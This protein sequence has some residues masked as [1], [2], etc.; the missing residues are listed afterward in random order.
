M[1]PDFSFYI[2]LPYMYRYGPG[3]C[4]GGSGAF[5]DSLVQCFQAHGGTLRLNAEV[6]EV[7]IEDGEARGLVLDDGEQIRAS[8]AVV[9]GL[10]VTQVFPHMVP[11]VELP[12][13][14]QHRI[15]NLKHSDF[16]AMTVHLALKEPLK[17]KAMGG[18]H[19]GLL[20]A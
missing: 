20:L 12:A 14:F 18:E 1:E 11:G 15:D 4:I 5:A 7:L 6:T 17:F 10:H 3:I 16:Q 19:R 8:K 13:G 2:I 9:T